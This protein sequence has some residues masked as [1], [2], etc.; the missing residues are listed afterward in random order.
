ML[1]NNGLG[2]R[3]SAAITAPGEAAM[4]RLTAELAARA[5]VG[6]YE[7][8]IGELRR[9]NAEVLAAAEQVKPVTIEALLARS[10]LEAGI[11]EMTSRAPPLRRTRA[12]RFGRSRSPTSSAS[13]SADLSSWSTSPRDKA[14]SRSGRGLRR[15]SIREKLAAS[16][17][18]RCQRRGRPD[19]IEG[20]VPRGRGPAGHPLRL[21]AQPDVDP[22]AGAEV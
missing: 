14:R 9:L 22:V 5:A 7:A 15:T 4:E 19:G 8:A 18:C 12:Q 21:A 11:E 1:T 10:D 16:Q 6:E 17:P 20:D 2:E 13:T 3:L